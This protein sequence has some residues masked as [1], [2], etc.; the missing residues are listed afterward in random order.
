MACIVTVRVY[1]NDKFDEGTMI[2]T[3]TSAPFAAIS[4]RTE[5]R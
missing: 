1:G 3:R 4:G 2:R 5:R